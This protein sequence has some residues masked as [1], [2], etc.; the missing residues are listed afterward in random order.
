ML[1]LRVMRGVSELVC[2]SDTGSSEVFE[3]GGLITRMGD[4]YINIIVDDRNREQQNL[5]V[6][7]QLLLRATQTALLHWKPEPKAICQI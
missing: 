7:S 5:V 6:R 1:S 4:T 2:A 3:E